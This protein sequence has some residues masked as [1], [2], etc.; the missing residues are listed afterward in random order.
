MSHSTRRAFNSRTRSPVDQFDLALETSELY[1]TVPYR[2]IRT[3]MTGVV[4]PTLHTP[5]GLL[6]VQ[7]RWE[8]QGLRYYDVQVND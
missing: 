8:P 4:F 1:L 7:P 6:V 3:D 2:T 5:P